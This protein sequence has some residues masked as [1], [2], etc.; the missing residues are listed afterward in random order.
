MAT[1]VQSYRVSIFVVTFK[2]DPVLNR[3]LHSICNEQ[4]PFGVTLNVT[5]LNNFGGVEIAPQLQSRVKVLNNEARPDNSTGHLA[6]SWNQAIMHAFGSLETPQSD[7]VIMCQNDV[8]FKQG[9]LTNILSC[10]T[11]YDYVTIGRGDEVQVMTLNGLKRIGMFDER[12]CN[13]GYQEA[14]YFLKARLLHAHKVSINDGL[15]GRLWNP[16][17]GIFET[18]LQPVEIGCSRKDACHVDS[19]KHHDISLRMFAHKWGALQPECWRQDLLSRVASVPKQYMYYPYFERHL[20][21]LDQKYL[22]H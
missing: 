17:P 13:I 16:I 22:V 10:M 7:C 14:D 5:V 4:V 21:D 3:C 2:N 9:Y 20:P 19:L 15:H 18:V 12:F 1:P 8:V 11:R 6:R